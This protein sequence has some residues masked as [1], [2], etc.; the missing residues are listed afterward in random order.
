MRGRTG[1]IVE[2]PCCPAVLERPVLLFYRYM[3]PHFTTEAYSWADPENDDSGFKSGVENGL[4][5][6]FDTILLEFPPPKFIAGTFVGPIVPPV[7]SERIPQLSKRHGLYGIQ[8][9]HS[10]TNPTKDDHHRIR[11][12][13]MAIA[14]GPNDLMAMTHGIREPWLLRECPSLE[15]HLSRGTARI[16]LATRRGE[17]ILEE[18]LWR[19]PQTRMRGFLLIESLQEELWLNDST[20]QLQHPV[21][22]LLLFYRYMLPYFTSEAYSWADPENR[23][24]GFKTGAENCFSLI[25]DGVFHVFHQQWILLWHLMSSRPLRSFW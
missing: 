8:A 16:L 23:N 9:F 22:W 13:R 19:I 25:D 18:P 6:F 7:S 3:L 12:Y 17:D 5:V 4:H 20:E 11:T 14:E 1:L 15:V 24:S 2:L 10:W 21:E